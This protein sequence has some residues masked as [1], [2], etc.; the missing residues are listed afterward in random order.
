MLFRE[1]IRP[2]V[3]EIEVD[4]TSPSRTAYARDGKILLDSGDAML[5][6]SN[7]ALLLE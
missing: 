2:L 3:L 4:V 5:A 1:I 7:D 6:E